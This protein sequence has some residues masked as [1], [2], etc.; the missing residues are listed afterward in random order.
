[1]SDA[2]TLAFYEREAPRYVVAMAQGAARSLSEQ[3]LAR[4][5]PRL[6][7]GAH[8]LELGCGGGR[9]GRAGGQGQQPPN[10]KTARPPR[11]RN[12]FPLLPCSSN[13]QR[14]QL[15]EPWDSPRRRASQN[16]AGLQ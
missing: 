12:Q 7:P 8:V 15:S 5:L 14:R 9:E 4:F 2:A 11:K 3:F 1:M 6:A 16:P 13:R 10:G